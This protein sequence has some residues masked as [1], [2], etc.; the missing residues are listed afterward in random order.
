[1]NLPQGSIPLINTPPQK[2]EVKTGEVFD[3]T[4]LRK[5]RD[6]FHPPRNGKTGANNGPAPRQGTKKPR[7][8]VSRL[9]GAL[10][11]PPGRV[12]RPD[13]SEAIRS[14]SPAPSSEQPK[15]GD[16]LD[17]PREGGAVG[18]SG[19]A[20]TATGEQSPRTSGMQQAVNGEPVPNFS[21][22]LTGSPRQAE[23]ATT[24]VAIQP[25][26]PCPCVLPHSPCIFHI[27]AAL[28]LPDEALNDDSSRNETST[29]GVQLQ[30]HSIPHAVHDRTPTQTQENDVGG[31]VAGQSEV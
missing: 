31:H 2:S 25:N 12:P 29:Q 28:Y 13:F 6:P 30:D 23:Q 5:D 27:A 26:Q 18:S 19:Q 10:R 9:P 14:S 3:L 7:G 4:G 21:V 20:S 22:P 17:T 8:P 1:M 24:P 11:E 16:L 15:S